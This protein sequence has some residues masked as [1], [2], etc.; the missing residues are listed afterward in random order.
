MKRP[1]AFTAEYNGIVK[2]LETTCQVCKA[3]DQEKTTEEHPTLKQFNALWD[4]G[5]TSS[6]IAAGDFC[7]SHFNGNTKFSSQMPWTHDIDFVKEIKQIHK[8]TV[9]KSLRNLFLST[10]FDRFGHYHRLKVTSKLTFSSRF[11]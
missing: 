8:Q 1:M 11:P 3:Y 7:I 5:A 2:T 6:I 9:S 4:T 10:K